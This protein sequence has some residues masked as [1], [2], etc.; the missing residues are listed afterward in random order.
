MPPNPDPS[1][2]RPELPVCAAIRY[3]E[4]LGDIIIAGKR[5]HDCLRGAALAGLRP[6]TAR[7]QGFMTNHGR[8]VDRQTA[9]IL[10]HKEGILSASPDG[11]R[12]RELFSEDLY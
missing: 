4:K 12:G 9:F 6:A 10:I 8:F 11:Y 1:P 7:E 5:H 3:Q 2:S